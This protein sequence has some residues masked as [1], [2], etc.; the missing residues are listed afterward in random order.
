MNE[1]KQGV[2]SVFLRM[3]MADL[4]AGKVIPLGDDYVGKIYERVFPLPL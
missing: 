2:R 4:T 3:Y 1:I